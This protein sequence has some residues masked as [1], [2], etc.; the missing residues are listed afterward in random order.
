MEYTTPLFARRFPENVNF[1][2]VRSALPIPQRSIMPGK[3]L[4][5]ASPEPQEYERNTR[6]TPHMI[7]NPMRG[8]LSFAA[9]IAVASASGAEFDPAQA[10]Q[11]CKTNPRYWQYRGEPVVLLGGSREDNLFQI[12]DI[13]PHLK[14]LAAVGGNYIRNTMSSRDDGDVWPFALGDDGKYDLNSPNPL[15]YER[16]DTC[17]RLAYDQDI[18]VQ[19]ELWD[20]FDY[21]R[22]VWERN[23]YRPAN[24][25]TY[26]VE[27]SGL[28]NHY[29]NHPGSNEN[30]FFYSVPALNNNELL[31]TY[32]HAHIDRVLAVALKY[33]NVLY[34]MDNET[35][36]AEEWGAYWADYVRTKAVNT[37]VVAQVT[38]MWDDWNL[39][40]AV[41]RRTLDRPDRYTFADVSQN[42][43]QKGQAHWNNLQWAL[44]H[45]ADAPRP[46]NN[47][48]IYGAAEGPFGNARDATERFWRGL[49]GGA[50]SIRFHRPDAGIGLSREAQTHIK[51]ARMLCGQFDIVHATPDTASQRITNRDDNEAYLT[52]IDTDSYAV[53]F[54]NGGS[55]DLALDTAITKGRV[56]WL[57]I[58][59][60]QWSDEVMFDA[61]PQ[62]QLTSPGPG[63]W[64]ALVRA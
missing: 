42:N 16:L 33:P 22:D 1:P 50:A 3:R 59:N 5:K 47:V 29:P 41:H 58:E 55:V 32:Q 63:H 35:A 27:S 36:G 18:I 14:T 52:Y 23:P 61:G 26:T 44:Q 19:I 21:A 38:E 8:M 15:Y 57:N 11:P 6:D 64:V 54:P 10:I 20:R 46:L 17:L 2:P 31:L 53:Y 34:C 62:L 39:T 40:S 49:I 30:P 51:A 7:A 24:N 56:T 43:H 45:V 60:A 37:G 12:P 4:A 13:E 28:K 9:I 25:V 48:K